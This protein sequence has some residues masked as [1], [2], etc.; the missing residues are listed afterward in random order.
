MAVGIGQLAVELL[1]AT[2]AS[3]LPPEPLRTRLERA[4][5]L[6]IQLVA[7]YAPDA[8]EDVH[9]SAV[10]RVAGYIINSPPHQ[11]R[12]AVA[13][14]MLQSGAASL[15]DLFRPLQVVD[16]ADDVDLPVIGP[17]EAE[18]EALRELLATLRADLS[19]YASHNDLDAVENELREL[20]SQVQAGERADLANY[21]TKSWVDATIARLQSEIDGKHGAL[22]PSEQRVVDRFVFVDGDLSIDAR[23]YDD[24]D[25]KIII[26]DSNSINGQSIDFAGG[27]IPSDFNCE[28]W[29]VGSRC[30]FTDSSPVAIQSSIPGDALLRGDKAVVYKIQN[31]GPGVVRLAVDYANRGSHASSSSRV[32]QLAQ[33]ITTLRALVATN[34]SDIGS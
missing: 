1:L 9:D 32:E 18:V 16:Y 19:D 27:N 13:N 23:H 24:Y 6:A 31:T 4:R 20:I 34:T 21:Y 5:A 10:I 30:A 8:P 11:Q 33:D 2:D 22:S 15:L 7:R 17:T 12:A 26:A 25:G 28:V 29:C 14:A 3:V